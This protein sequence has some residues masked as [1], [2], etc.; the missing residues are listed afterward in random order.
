[1]FFLDAHNH[2][3]DARL[4]NRRKE[5]IA[6]TKNAGITRMVV[7]GTSEAD[8]PEVAALA[9]AH[10]DLVIP[11]FGLHP[12]RVA[13]RGKNWQ[14]ALRD[15]LRE[16][17]SAPIGEIGLDRWL[18]GHDLPSQETVFRAQLSLAE[19]MHR[20]VVIHCLKAFGLLENCLRDHFPLP[21]GFLLHSYGGSLEQMKTFT[22][23]G[24]WFSC[25]AYFFHERKAAQ[26]T[27]F[28]NIPLERLL[29]ETDAP[30]MSGP[31]ELRPH[32]L[33]DCE[34]KPLN[35]P[36][37]L[38]ALYAAAAQLRGMDPVAFSSA[39]TANFQKFFA[40]QPIS[41]APMR[42]REPFPARF[43]DNP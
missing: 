40:L 35:H 39:I 4:V 28:Q 15:F 32:P 20:P 11:A 37:N 3:Q 16:F 19:E 42:L 7:N 31:E 33:T 1:M 17:P 6:A 10:P 41:S 23:L 22:A 38:P 29:L 25:S 18:P 30:D 5:I 9:R 21:R 43:P 26:Q 14:D 8:W 27:V 34:G 12:W 36:A 24:G 2:L 13:E